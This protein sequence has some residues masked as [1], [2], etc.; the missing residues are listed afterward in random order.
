MVHGL[1]EPETQTASAPYFRAI[2][3]LSTGI[4]YL[5]QCLGTLHRIIPGTR[6]EL[7]ITSYFIIIILG[8]L[9]I[10]QLVEG[11]DIILPAFRPFVQF[12]QAL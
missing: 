7:L 10:Q 8:V 9:D 2:A 5:L 6:I 4:D 11:V 1:V 12:A 3:I